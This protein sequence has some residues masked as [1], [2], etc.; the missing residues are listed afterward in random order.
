M[1]LCADAGDGPKT[2]W[3]PRFQ[4]KSR[5]IVLGKSETPIGAKT[6]G[7]DGVHSVCCGDSEDEDEDEDDANDDDDDDDDVGDGSVRLRRGK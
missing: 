4:V 3:L 1:R 6:M 7:V 5:R 2:I